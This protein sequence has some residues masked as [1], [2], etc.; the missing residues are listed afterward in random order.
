MHGSIPE[1]VNQARE[2]T[3]TNVFSPVL[4]LEPASWS[5]GLL[6]KPRKSQIKVGGGQ[7]L[8]RSAL[9]ECSKTPFSLKMS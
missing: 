1:K 8:N 6:A 7:K 9:A 4:E 2:I 3:A 5:S